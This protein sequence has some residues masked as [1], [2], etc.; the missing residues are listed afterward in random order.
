MRSIFFVLL[1][2]ATSI[3]AMPD[4]TDGEGEASNANTD[5]APAPVP[6]P[7]PAPAPANN[8]GGIPD[9]NNRRLVRIMDPAEAANGNF[10]PKINSNDFHTTKKKGKGDIRA[11]VPPE[12]EIG[13]STFRTPEEA[14]AAAKVAVTERLRKDGKLDEEA[15]KHQRIDSQV[16][17]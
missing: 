6:A 11:A 4:G 14:K 5:P 15:A 12:P 16:G 10:V 17:Y 7:A 9:P 2:L 13:L 1:L 8:D 3:R